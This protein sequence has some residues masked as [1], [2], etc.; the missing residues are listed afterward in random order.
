MIWLYVV[1]PIFAF[2][3]ALP[4]L[5]LYYIVFPIIE[6]LLFIPRLLFYL[7]QLFLQ[8]FF[9]P[10]DWICVSI[11]GILDGILDGI[12]DSVGPPE[13]QPMAYQF[14]MAIWMASIE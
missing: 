6:I 2:F 7:W 13:W 12:I 9:K 14:P 3:I 8:L 4:W 11:W 5:I 1:W 10:I